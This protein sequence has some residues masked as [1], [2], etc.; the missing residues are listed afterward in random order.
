MTE[1]SGIRGTP[2][3][4]A[5]VTPPVPNQRSLIVTGPLTV[6]RRTTTGSL[7]RRRG[8]ARSSQSRLPLRHAAAR[9]LHGE[10]CDDVISTPDWKLAGTLTVSGPLDARAVR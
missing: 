3:S 7:P 8:R 10:C 2:P 5:E 6:D 1:I 4:V 9:Q